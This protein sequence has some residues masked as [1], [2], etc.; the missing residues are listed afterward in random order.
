M[1]LDSKST[2]LKITFKLASFNCLMIGPDTC[3]FYYFSGDVAFLVTLGMIFIRPFNNES[4]YLVSECTS[5]V[6]CDRT[7]FCIHESV[8]QDSFLR[9]EIWRDS[10]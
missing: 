3:S 4:L 7:H 10:R 9:N 5:Q 1:K 2:Y 8:T 6:V